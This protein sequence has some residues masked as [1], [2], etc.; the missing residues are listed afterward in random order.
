MKKINSYVIY[1]AGETGRQAA[2]LLL[3]KNQTV[4]AIFDRNPKI[5]SYSGVDVLRIDEWLRPSNMEEISCINAIHNH[6]IDPKSINNDLKAV[7]FGEVLNMVEFSKL[8][9]FPDKYWLSSS[10]SYDS[11]IPQLERLLP[12]LADDLSRRLLS[13][14]WGYW[15]RGVLELCPEPSLYDEYVPADVPRYPEVLRLIDCGAS[16]GSTLTRLAKAGYQLEA[17]LAFEPDPVNFKKL[18]AKT[19]DFN[20][21][22]LPLGLWSSEMQL[23]FA[24]NSDNSLASGLDAGG[25]TLIQCASLDTIAINFNPNLIKFDIEGSE[26]EVLHG[27]KNLIRKCRPNL[28]VS[29]YHRPGDP[30]D[31]LDLLASWDLDYQFYLRCHEFN[32]YGLVLYCISEK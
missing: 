14:T 32:T 20:L 11:R 23:S 31:I 8:W 30:L 15:S 18:L 19:N 21:M 12:L 28:C 29:V 6:Y 10:F 24:A 25:T 26:L 17:A 16:N 2:D 5:S 22:P 3:Q 9:P 13:D 1:S 4:L 7:G 27:A